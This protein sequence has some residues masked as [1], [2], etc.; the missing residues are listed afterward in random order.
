MPQPLVQN[1]FDSDHFSH[2]NLTETISYMDSVDNSLNLLSVFTPSP[3]STTS[4]SVREIEERSGVLA[5][6]DRQAPRVKSSGKSTQRRRYIEVPHF[7]D[8]TNISVQELQNYNNPNNPNNLESLA[9]LMNQKLSVLV[10]SHRFTLEFM[11]IGC[12]KGRI[13]DGEG[14]EFIDLFSEYK[15]AQQVV[16]FKLNVSTTK[17]RSMCDNAYQ[18]VYEG[19]QNERMTGVRA[20]C[21]R[22]F[23]DAFVE[24]E[25][26][27]EV[28][29]GYE[30]AQARL[31]DR[32]SDGF[33]FGGITFQV[34]KTKFKS[35]NG[36][37]LETIP[38][39]EAILYPDGTS[40]TFFD[41][42]APANLISEVNTLGKPLY[43]SQG[44]DHS[45][46]QKARNVVVE[47]ESNRLLFC[48]RPKALVRAKMS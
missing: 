42:Q 38:D 3:I 39:G 13:V 20:L 16:N 37:E 44:L 48:H 47:T 29:R 26:V 23:F 5:F 1:P 22:S 43:A 31:G 41:Y 18:K 36:Q 46:P 10:N 2:A 28:Y 15:I 24:H 35:K 14:T 25:S 9:N 30:K 4:F 12:L 8:D 21:S 45:D 6:T 32:V 11:M 33:T 34:Q 7:T 27:V 17:V 40:N 19:L